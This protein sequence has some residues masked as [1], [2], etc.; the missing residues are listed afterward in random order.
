M[1]SQVKVWCFLAMVAIHP[2]AKAQ[3]VSQQSA[4]GVNVEGQA[5]NPG[6]YRLEIGDLIEV[7]FFYNGELNDSIQIR[8]DGFISMPMIGD[9]AVAGKTI[10]EVRLLLEGQ[11]KSIIREPVV[12][13]Q[14]RNYANRRIFVGGEVSR[15]GMLPL[16]GRQTALSAIVEAGGLRPSAKRGE[17]L[18][19]RRGLQGAP[20]VT[21]LSMK[22]KDRGPSEAILFE[23]QPFDLILVTESGVSK[24]NRAVD[25]YIRQMIPGLLTGGFSYLSNANSILAR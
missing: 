17:I 19:V 5:L 16:V 3:A 18:L 13:I 2:A 8:P 6:L 23:L 14:I 7:K 9:V 24:A 1:T 10:S 20:V 25:Q 21:R 22:S 11:Y 15:P 12:T 4:P